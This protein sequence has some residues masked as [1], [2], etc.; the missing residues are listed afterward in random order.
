MELSLK[1][2][3]RPGLGLVLLANISVYVTA[4]SGRF[5]SDAWIATLTNI[6]DLTPILALSVLTGVINAQLGHTTKARLVFWK[7][8]DPLPGSRAF[9]EY[10]C[11]DPRI[12]AAALRT[13]H[14]PLPTAPDAQNALWYK[15]YQECNM[16]A[17]IRQVH[18][19]YLFSRD[20]AG[21]SFLLLLGLGP[22]AFWQLGPVSVAMMYAAAL[23][24]QYLVVRRAARNHGER[25]VASVLA[26]KTAAN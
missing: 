23:A 10:A 5:S 12:D 24:L 13:C 11:K 19:E 15:W 20:Y 7:W 26:R 16:D 21:I 18:R 14:D 3:N 6:Q 25:F 9:S 22:L 1:D 8:S 4:L 17:S 2:M